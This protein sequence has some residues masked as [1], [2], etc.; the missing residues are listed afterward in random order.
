M[1]SPTRTGSDL[2]YDDLDRRLPWVPDGGPI[3]FH[4]GLGSCAM[5]W[6]GWDAALAD[7]HR[8]VRFDLRGHGRSGVP[9]GFAWTLDALVE[10][11]TA[12]ADAAG[13]DR[14]HLVGESIGGTASMA[15]AARNPGRV[16]TLTVSNGAHRGATIRGMSPWTKVLDEGGSAAWSTFMMPTRF[17]DD[18]VDPRARQWFEQQQA[19]T[20]PVAVR[21]LAVML[22]GTDLTAELG[23]ITMPT[24]LMHPDSSPYI[25]VSL[26]AELYE[27]LPDA[28][29]EVVAGVRHGLPFSHAAHC[30]NSLAAFLNDRGG[31]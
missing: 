27:L 1:N 28:R 11:L 3:L 6:A 24:L 2:H 10:D 25:P 15:F 13:L 8:L 20:N 23:A 30:S 9:E 19:T 26:M 22:A 29:L 4:H 17:A 14:F 18:A 12:V 5:A 7:R 21:A 16:R 31:A